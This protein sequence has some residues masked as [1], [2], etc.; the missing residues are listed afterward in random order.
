[1]GGV[2]GRRARMLAEFDAEGSPVFIFLLS[3]GMRILGFWGR[4]ARMLAEFN[5]EGS[6]VFIFL[7]STRAGGLGLNLQSADTV[8]MFDSDWNPQADLQVR[9]GG[10]QGSV[11]A[12]RG[13]PPPSICS[14]MP[15]EESLPCIIK[16]PHLCR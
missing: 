6:P 3:V 15:N 13:L 10:V 7:L 5:A 11:T 9:R 16:H 4:R 12:T 1:M 14:A 2:C 8:L